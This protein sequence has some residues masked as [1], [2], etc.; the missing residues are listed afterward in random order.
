[1]QGLQKKMTAG[2]QGSLDPSERLD[3]VFRILEVSESSENVDNDIELAVERQA[4]HIASNPLD[5]SSLRF[6][7]RT[8]SIE[9]HL[10]E[11]V[12]GHVITPFR[13]LDGVA[14]VT[15]GYVQNSLTG[16]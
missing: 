10:A 8:C 14:A 16:R 9:E 15:A 4:A 2:P 7:I 6:G 13:Q 11:V 1:M 12:S 5:R 3:V